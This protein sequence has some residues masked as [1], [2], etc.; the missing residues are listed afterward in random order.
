MCS[1]ISPWAPWVDGYAYIVSIYHGG[2]LNRY[3]VPNT[4]DGGVQISRIML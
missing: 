1:T 4:N 3:T 2:Y